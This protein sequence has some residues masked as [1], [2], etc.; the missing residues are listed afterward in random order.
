MK[1][2]VLLTFAVAAV[3]GTAF[4]GV[5]TY[6]QEADAGSGTIPAAAGPAPDGSITCTLSVSPTTVTN[7]QVFEMTVSYSPSISGDLVEKFSVIP[8]PSL[9]PT[10]NEATLRGKQFVGFGAVSG[11]FES[12]VVPSATNIKGVAT[13]NVDV[14]S[15]GATV[16]SAS[17][18]LTVS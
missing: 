9:S 6:A 8:W 18:T 13:V 2:L 10:F 11:S 3:L 12:A 1:K 4:L 15:G 14:T 17:T 5:T 16:C 7:G